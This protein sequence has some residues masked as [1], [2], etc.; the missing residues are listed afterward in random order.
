MNNK[1]MIVNHHLCLYNM[2]FLLSRIEHLS[3]ILVNR[4]WN[5]LFSR[6]C[7]RQKAWEILFNFIRCSQPLCDLVYFLWNWQAF[8]NQPFYLLNISTADCALIQIKE[9]AR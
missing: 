9:K 7:E 2:S 4:S 6:I 5:L 1:T 8:S 3:S